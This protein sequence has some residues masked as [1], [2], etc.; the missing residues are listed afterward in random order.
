MG[1]KLV[2][3]YYIVSNDTIDRIQDQVHHLHWRSF[4]RKLWQDD[5]PGLSR[6]PAPT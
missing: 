3:H 5:L 6:L 1:D 2:S 4:M